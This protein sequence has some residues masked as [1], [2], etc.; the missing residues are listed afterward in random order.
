MGLRAVKQQ[1][2]AL[3]AEAGPLPEVDYSGRPEALLAVRD[4]EAAADVTLPVAPELADKLAALP[5]HQ[6]LKVLLSLF[7]HNEPAF[8]WRAVSLLGPL[9]AELAEQDMEAA[10]VM[11]R[12]LMWSLNDESGGIGWGAPEAMAECLVWHAGLA[13]EYGH[14]LV[15]FM[16]EDGFFLEYPP[17]QRGLMWGLGRL[18]AVRPQL[19]RQKKA[20]DY[21]L[22]YLSSPDAAVRGLAARALGLLQTVAARQP[23]Q[24]LLVDRAPVIYYHR[25]RLL[26]VTVADL[27]AV[28]VR[29]LA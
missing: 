23:L 13:E 14:I 1:V 28:A 9:V 16:R 10:R 17:L 19:L 22:P 11:M 18:A 27:A 8:R 6:V 12:R 5:W 29:R 21:L 24:A 15:S 7:C 4:A 25:E 26:T 3:L 2:L 20:P